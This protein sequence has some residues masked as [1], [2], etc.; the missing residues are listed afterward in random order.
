MTEPSEDPLRSTVYAARVEG[1]DGWVI[2][3]L[4]GGAADAPEA[5]GSERLRVIEFR[6]LG[7]GL[8]GAGSG[9]M[10][11]DA[12]ILVYLARRSGFVFDQVAE[13]WR[14]EGDPVTPPPFETS[15]VESIAV[16]FSPPFVGWIDATL[17]YGTQS[18]IIHCSNVFDPFPS[19]LRFLE[20]VLDG[21][22]PRLSIDEEGVFCEWHTFA[23]PPRKKRMASEPDPERPVRFVVFSRHASATADEQDAPGKPTL[24]LVLPR[25]ELVRSIYAAWRQ[26]VLAGSS[27]VRWSREWLQSD[28][29]A[30]DRP[31]DADGYFIASDADLRDLLSKRLEAA[32][33]FRRGP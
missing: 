10:L 9:A 23:P 6:K 19:I 1:R 20:A 5:L 24:D 31:V 4:P 22:H 8:P 26:L 30:V 15:W 2:G 33:G 17:A 14:A 25:R 21:G 12:G 27:R 32:M 18:V 3:E 16:A 7:H 13:C 11:Q 29:E 28:L